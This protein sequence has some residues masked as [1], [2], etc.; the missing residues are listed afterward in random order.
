MSVFMPRKIY[1]H[2]A[3]LNDPITQGI[4]EKLPEI[5]VEVQSKPRIKAEEE[6]DPVEAGKQIWFLTSS[7]G[8]LV[9]EC[10]ATP[11]QLCC[12]YRVINI[13]TNCPID[14]SYCILQGYLN[15]PFITINVN[16]EDI[17][18][19]VTE[20]LRS[21][22]QHIFRIGT[23][24]LS[25]SLALEEYTGFSFLLASFFLSRKNGFFEIKTKSH[26]IEEL[27]KLDPQ[28]KVGISWSVNP[29]D[30]IQQEEKGASTLALRLKAAA[31]GMERGYLIGFHFDP[32]IHYPGWEEKYHAV[33]NAIYASLKPDRI[34]WISVGGFRYP[35]FLKPIIRERFPQSNILCGELLPGRDGKFR[36]LKTIRVEMYRKIVD[37]I[38]A[39]NPKQFIYLCMESAEV[40]DQVFGFHPTNRNELDRL[41]SARIREF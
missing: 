17:K 24:E 18:G 13:I 8:Q 40:W 38:R 32:I 34:I 15:N 25:D 28:G 5:P 20:L 37:W 19:Q 4:V 30:I 12:R 6:T 14:C 31:R 2:P 26:H 39:Y 1:I 22:P 29:E 23:G 9:K 33:V 16:L 21:D 27:L 41:F 35:R 3:V 10:P 36:Y 11:R 7:P